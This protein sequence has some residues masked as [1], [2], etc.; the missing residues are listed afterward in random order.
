MS[1][2]KGPDRSNPLITA[3]ATGYVRRP[4]AFHTILERLADLLFIQLF[5]DVIGKIVHS[6]P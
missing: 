1:D 5:P 4:D 2:S 3:C 6:L